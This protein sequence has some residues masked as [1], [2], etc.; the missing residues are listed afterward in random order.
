MHARNWIALTLCMAGLAWPCAL[1]AL[2]GEVPAD[3]GRDRG[4]QAAS[5]AAMQDALKDTADFKIVDE[6]PQVLKKVA[7]RYPAAA[8][9]RGDQGLVHVRA[10]V[11]KDGMPIE[12]SVPAGQGVTP[13]LDRAAV[14]AVSQWTFVP[15]K[16]K[17]RPVAVWV[18]VPVN[19]RLK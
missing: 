14:D 1:T 2:A 19:F 16:S 8:R 15:A 5:A 7:P 10:L 11:K 13:E 12:V 3:A 6:V 4:T 17:G 18:V 9:K